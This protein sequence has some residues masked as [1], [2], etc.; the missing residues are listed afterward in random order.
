MLAIGFSTKDQGFVG[1]RPISNTD[2]DS[3]RGSAQVVSDYLYRQFGVVFDQVLVVGPSPEGPEV[4]SHWNLGKDYE[5]GE[6][7]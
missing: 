1:S 2:G 3:E 6:G 4:Y 5:L 7:G